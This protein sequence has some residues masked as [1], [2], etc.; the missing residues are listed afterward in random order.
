MA[1]IKNPEID[2]EALSRVVSYSPETGKFTWLQGRCKGR[3]G[4]NVGSDGYIRINVNYARCLAHRLAW[5]IFY[6][7][8]PADQ[9]DHING[10]RSD[11]RI[12]NLRAATPQQNQ[13]NRAISKNNSSGYKGVRRYRYVVNKPWN[14]SITVNRKP[15]SLGYFASPEEAHKAYCAA[16]SQIYGEFARSR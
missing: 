11:N 9:I 6:G 10:D 15:R 16:A 8:W 3:V 13:A 12:V 7:A 1:S 5:L 2:V 14:A 4:G